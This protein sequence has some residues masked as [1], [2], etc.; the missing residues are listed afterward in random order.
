MF[1]HSF[2]FTI[3]CL[4]TVL[5]A[6][7]LLIAIKRF[8][9]SPKEQILSPSQLEKDLHLENIRLRR[10]ICWLERRLTTP[11]AAFAPDAPTV[12]HPAASNHYE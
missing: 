12:A 11:G 9:G 5:A 4:G 1:W 2:W 3:G 8:S 6:I 10:R 7:V